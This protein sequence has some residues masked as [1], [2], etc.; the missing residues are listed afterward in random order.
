MDRKI[1]G[2]WGEDQAAKYLKRR[3]YRIIA[4]N[5]SC[6]FGEIDIIARKRDTV[7]FVEVKLRKN[8]EFATAAENVSPSKIERIRTTAMMWIAQNESNAQARF[9][10]I[11]IYA[12]E[13]IN[14]AHPRINHIPNAFQ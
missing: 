6:R 10:V 1:I 5:Y 7:V 12:P 11:E 8:S 9:D 4:T 14:T 2:R 3:F 13:G